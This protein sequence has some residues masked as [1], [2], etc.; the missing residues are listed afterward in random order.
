MSSWKPLTPQS[1]P[2]PQSV[3]TAAGALGYIR[4]QV[5]LAANRLI[6]EQ[7]TPRLLFPRRLTQRRAAATVTKTKIMPSFKKTKGKNKVATVAGVKRMIRQQSELKQMTL[8]P[9]WLAGMVDNTLYTFNVTAQLTQ[10]LSVNNRIGDEVNLERISGMFTFLTG[11]DAGYY[12][13]RFL[14]LYSGEESNPNATNFAAITGLA[15]PEVFVSGASGFTTAPI[16]TKACTVLH[17]ELITIN[18]Q[19]DLTEDGATVPFNVNLRNFKMKYQSAASVYGKTKNLYFVVVAS[20]SASA[21]ALRGVPLC[22]YKVQ[23]RDS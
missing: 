15:G 20:G 21:T 9:S 1:L 5:R 22:N 14:V 2:R 12:F 11:V 6:L 18:S 13:C 7:S 4:S 23:F 16:N 3:V 8:G 17:D 19:I 10:G